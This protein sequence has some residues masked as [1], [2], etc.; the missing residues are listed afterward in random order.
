MG[1]FSPF[2]NATLVFKVYS[3]FAVDSV[4][5]NRVPVNTDETYSANIQLKEPTFADKPG[6]DETDLPCSGRLLSPARFS[7]KV[8]VGSTA[9]CTVNGITGTL[10]LTDL[11]SNTFPYVRQTLLQ[12]FSGVFEQSGKAG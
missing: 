10:R 1:A 4:T 9:D 12:Q 7:E 8:K 6:I 2:D 3:S 11:G 5:G